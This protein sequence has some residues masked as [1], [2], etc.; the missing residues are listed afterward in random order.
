MLG[1]ASSLSRSALSVARIDRTKYPEKSFPAADYS[2]GFDQLRF[3]DHP[4]VENFPLAGD[5]SF[6]P[7]EPSRNPR[8]REMISDFAQQLSGPFPGLVASSPYDYGDPDVWNS[9]R[10]AT[11]KM[12]DTTEE[13][14]DNERWTGE[15]EENVDAVVEMRDAFEENLSEEHQAAIARLMELGFDKDMVTPVM[16]MC[17]GD[18]KQARL[19]L[20]ETLRS[21]P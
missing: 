11:L 18:E 16:F 2:F 13:E 21:M 1:L 19:I 9:L 12:P 17:Q 4:P 15:E 6:L 8:F 5:Q 10:R 14:T 20:T 7:S 3:S